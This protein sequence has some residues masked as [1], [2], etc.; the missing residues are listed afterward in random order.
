MMLDA[1]PCRPCSASQRFIQSSTHNRILFRF[2]HTPPCF[3]TCV[4]PLVFSSSVFRHF[5]FNRFPYS[6]RVCV[7]C[8]SA[9]AAAHPLSLLLRPHVTNTTT[10][11]RGCTRCSRAV[12]SGSTTET[13]D[14]RLFRFRTKST[15]TSD[16]VF[17][18]RFLV[19]L[20]AQARDL[21]LSYG[22]L[23]LHCVYRQHRCQGG[24][25][26]PFARAHSGLPARL[27]PQKTQQFS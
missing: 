16:S 5:F 17:F 25:A 10:T 23:P 13:D 9:A 24:I 6:L 14:K 3:R 15:D 11:H 7:Q 21:A 1:W 8:G 20:L 26:R 4:F 19:L 22:V 2:S 12:V 27:Y 18:Y